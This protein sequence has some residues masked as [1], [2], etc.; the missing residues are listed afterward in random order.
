MSGGGEVEASWDFSNHRHLLIRGDCHD[1]LFVTI[2]F[3]E[4]SG[5]VAILKPHSSVYIDPT[6]HQPCNQVTMSAV[7]EG[8]CFKGCGHGWT[9]WASSIGGLGI[10]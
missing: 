3:L 8:V 10:R 2:I 7:G 4:K 1:P 5:H 6:P 9:R